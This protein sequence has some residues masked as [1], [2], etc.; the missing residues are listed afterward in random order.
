MALFLFTKA[1]LKG[2]PIN[3]FNHG[4]MVRD[5]TYIDDIVEGV[6]RAIDTPAVPNSLW[7]GLAPDPATSS[8][9]Y[10]IY[11]IGNNKPT[12]L[13]DYIG[14]IEQAIGKKANLRMMPMQD[15]DVPSTDADVSK[16][17]GR[18]GL[19]PQ[20]FCERGSSAG[21]LIGIENFIVVDRA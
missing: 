7:E 2:E 19:S 9:P 10:R 21:L 1:I 4:E 5:F 18:F 12:P 20:C 13:M 6:S 8:A 16:L 17:A 3:V 14:A 15:G 11:N